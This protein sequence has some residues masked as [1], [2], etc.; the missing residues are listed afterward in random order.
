MFEFRDDED[1][2]VQ[3][4][5]VGRKRV[6]LGTCLICAATSFFTNSVLK[7]KQTTALTWLHVSIMTRV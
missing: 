4:L 3:N 1:E 2:D 5:P 6:A 7:Q